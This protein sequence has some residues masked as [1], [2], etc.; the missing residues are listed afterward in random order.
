MINI[1]TLIK[2]SISPTVYHASGADFDKFDMSKVKSSTDMARHGLGIY[3][4]DDYDTAMEYIA[5]Y[6]VNG[7]GMM[8]HCKLHDIDSYVLWDELSTESLYMQ[9]AED[10]TE[11]GYET[12]GQSLLDDFESYGET[13]NNGSLYEH[14]TAIV[15][16]D[17]VNSYFV[18]NN[19]YGFV[20]TNMMNSNSTE[21]CCLDASNLYIQDKE[22]VT[23]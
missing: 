20:G 13:V 11:N 21:Y 3:F 14:V 9:I 17:N 12:D 22:M 16:E 23:M 2:E 10:L 8:Y 6:T 15:G 7:E 19:V 1:K 18:D 4:V 5:N